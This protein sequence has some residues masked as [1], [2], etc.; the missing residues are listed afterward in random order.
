M[1]KIVVD[2]REQAKSSQI[3]H[4]DPLIEEGRLRDEHVDAEI[5]EI[6]AGKKEGRTSDDERILYWHK[7]FSVSDIMLGNLAHQVAI[8]KGIGQQVTFYENPEPR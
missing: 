2:D 6:V 7:G 5:G 8:E 3:G 4:L 1:D